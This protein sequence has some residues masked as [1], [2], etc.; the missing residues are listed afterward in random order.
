MTCHRSIATG[1]SVRPS[2]LV[3]RAT[4]CG[5]SLPPQA[6][7]DDTAAE[8]RAASALKKVRPAL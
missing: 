8:T 6:S 4:T 2:V 1:G 7:P 3:P 5:L